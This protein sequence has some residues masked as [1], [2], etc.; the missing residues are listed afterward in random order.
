M[1]LLEELRGLLEKIGSSAFRRDAEIAPEAFSAS[2]I[3]ELIE[4]V[5]AQAMTG[6]ARRLQGQQL[7]QM[8][9]R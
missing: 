6:R 7:L 8:R 5:V 2:R 3:I 9:K 4:G 1:A